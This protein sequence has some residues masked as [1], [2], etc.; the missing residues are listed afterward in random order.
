MRTLPV[1]GTFAVFCCLF[2]LTGCGAGQ[3]TVQAKPPV[4]SPPIQ[5]P[6]ESPP[7]PRLHITG[8]IRR[9][10]RLRDTDA[11]DHADYAKRTNNRL[12]LVRLVENGGRVKK[13]DLLAE[14]DNTRQLDEALEAEAKYDDL[15]HQAK[16]K[17]PPRTRAMPRSG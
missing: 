15:G 7:T 11:T 13:E 2:G 6:L 5:P 8:T 12:T 10:P 16:Q 9:R 17:R 14:F 3:Q 1:L 4:T